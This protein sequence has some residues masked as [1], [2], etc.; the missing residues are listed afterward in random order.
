MQTPRSFVRLV[1][2]T[3]CFDI[4][5]NLPRLDSASPVLSLLVPSIDLLVVAAACWGVAQGAQSPRR[6]GRAVVCVLVA[7]LLAYATFS[8]FG[9][10]VCLHLFGSVGAL[11]V[12]ASLAVC[13]ALMAAAIS[14][15]YL[16]AGLLADGFQNPVVR[17]VFLL[18]VAL[19]AIAQVFTH[20]LVFTRSVL[21]R[22]VLDLVAQLH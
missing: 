8:R 5:L 3:F 11:R 18:V 15:S 2:G 1:A 9:L 17:N 12:A 4:L 7:F 20:N 21:A 13:V 16:I 19:S 10:D 6:G 14:A 22:A